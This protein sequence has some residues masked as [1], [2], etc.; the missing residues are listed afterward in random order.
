MLVLQGY[1]ARV[2]Q[3][4]FSPD[5]GAVLAVAHGWV[6]VWRLPAGGKPETLTD[7]AH[8][9]HA[10][11]TPDGSKLLAAGLNLVARDWAGGQATTARLW[12][13]VYAPLFALT[14]DGTRAVVVQN[15]PHRG[16][17]AW[18][19]CLPVDNLD[20]AAAFWSRDLPRRCSVRPLFLPDGDEFVV[21]ELGEQVA[22][23]PV[24]FRYV[25]RSA[26][27]G[28][29][30]RSVEAPDV[31]T[32]L[33]AASPD[34]RLLAGI[35][36]SRV[37]V[38]AADDLA[39]PVAVLKNDSRKEF[40][41]AAFHPNGKLLAT[42]GNDKTVKFWDTATWQAAKTFTWA[43]GRMRSIAFSPD[44]ALA[45]AGTDTGKVVVWDVDV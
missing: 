45:A 24:P 22:G 42:A 7:D 17:P 37:L 31:R 12:P 27:T 29:V 4:L 32:D 25:V 20:L 23:T 1:R 39:K 21:S 5:G 16:S 14:P 28:E 43:A 38:L 13:G 19:A 9:R 10:A 36:G 40:T 33:F 18:L 35:N 34:R 26:R 41:D 2:E 30:V 44:G 15:N 11:F 3:V 6:Q 8:V